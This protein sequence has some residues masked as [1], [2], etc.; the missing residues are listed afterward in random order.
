MTTTRQNK[1]AG[2]EKNAAPKEALQI[3][4]EIHTLAEM[5]RGQL[6]ASSIPWSTP[7]P[8]T[9]AFEPPTAWTSPMA[10]ESAHWTVPTHWPW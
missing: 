2:A 6:A 3:A 7:V 10:P 4:Y 1:T 8:P 5:I 9:T